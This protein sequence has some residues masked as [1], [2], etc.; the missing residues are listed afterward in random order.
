MCKNQFV[1]CRKESKIHNWITFFWLFKNYI[2]FSYSKCGKV[3]IGVEIDR[4]GEDENVVFESVTNM[5]LIWDLFVTHLRP[6]Y[7]SSI[8][9]AYETRLWECVIYMW[10]IYDSFVTQPVK[11]DPSVIH[12]VTHVRTICDSYVFY[13]W[14]M[15][16]IW[17]SPVTNL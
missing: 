14:I 17:N 1:T 16:P 15:S 2:H 9:W 12:P 6:I 3:V 11:C 4:F 13:L 8:T 7:N 5:W 10:L